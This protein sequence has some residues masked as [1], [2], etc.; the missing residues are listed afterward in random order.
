M[1]L[2]LVLNM[3]G[4]GFLNCFRNWFGRLVGNNNTNKTH[5]MTMS[6]RGW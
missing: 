4:V 2:K 3:F 5:I 6:L 1:A